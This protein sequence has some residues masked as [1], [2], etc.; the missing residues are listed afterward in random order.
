MRLAELKVMEQITNVL[1]KDRDSVQFIWNHPK[2]HVIH[3]IQRIIVS[4]I[5]TLCIDM[6]MIDEN[7]TMLADQELSLR[8]GM[9]PMESS[10]ANEFLL[11][12]EC[13]CENFCHKCSIRMSLNVSC[14]QD[15]Y[16]VTSKDFYC[17]DVRSRPLHESSLPDQFLGEDRFGPGIFIVPMVK[18]QRIRL[19]CIVRKGSGRIHGKWN[20]TSKATFIPS[21]VVKVNLKRYSNLNTIMENKLRI[22][23]ENQLRTKYVP[24][25]M[26]NAEPLLRKEMEEQLSD[27]NRT[28]T[29]KENE[30]HFQIVLK[31]KV[32]IM[33]DTL[34]S[35]H[36]DVLVEKNKLDWKKKW[37]DS[38]PRG[39]FKNID[40]IDDMEDFFKNEN[41][42]GK[43][44]TPTNNDA[45]IVCN[46]CITEAEDT[47]EVDNLIT[48]DVS[49]TKYIC[50]IVG[51]GV[52]SP[53]EIL[54]R[55]MEVLDDKLSRLQLE[56]ETYL[57][58]DTQ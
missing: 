51:L 56:M 28:F 11:P 6:V 25:F 7:T 54:L 2:Q 47:L 4:D 34:L 37:V 58:K 16:D 24:K 5:P 49:E 53:K 10:L 48:V 19:S 45:C 52:L 22:D 50:N 36:L 33:I 13:D 35:Q 44:W 39:V 31:E 46:A 32:D 12:D 17:E 9:I 41:E 21:P 57:E 27:S 26:K 40:S 43:W 1:H 23:I 30:D 55:G 18:N 42:N 20:P 3:A 29:F 14:Y 15:R 8:L 38:C